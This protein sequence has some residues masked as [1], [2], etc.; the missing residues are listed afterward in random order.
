[1]YTYYQTP[2]Q[3]WKHPHIT[4]NTH[5]HTHTFQNKLKQPQYKIHTKRNSH[6]NFMCPQYNVSGTF[7]LKNFTALHFTALNFKTK[8]LHMY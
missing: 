7:V 4:K 2:M 3:L 6:N 5:T 8:S 1:M